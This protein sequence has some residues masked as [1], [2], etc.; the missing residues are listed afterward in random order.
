MNTITK[1]TKQA[2]QHKAQ[3]RK[4]KQLRAGIIYQGPSMIDG[5]P[6]VAIATWTK[7][8]PKT[9]AVLQTY[10]LR[11]DMLPMQAIKAGADKAI[12]GT[13]P[14]R[15]PVDAALASGLP[16]PYGSRSC[17]VNVSRGV[18]V[19]Y[20]A[21]QRG[22]Y[23]LAIRENEMRE[24]GAGRIIRLGTYGDPAAVPARVWMH[25][26]SQSEAHTGYTHAWREERFSTLKAW[27][28]A[29][30]DTAQDH[31]E[32]RAAGWRTFRVR[33]RA[34]AVL[35]AEFICPASEEAGKKVTCSQCKACGGADGRKGSPV[36]IA[37]GALAKRFVI[38]IARSA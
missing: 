35:P 11:A 26:L 25:L 2:G 9:G 30:A 5:S 23:P 31:A 7:S 16:V 24:L 4:P 1:D 13:C 33:D 32:A 14:H 10:I 18:T 15:G 29:S 20:K 36:I 8:N 12:C 37:H 27:T 19:V 22:S 6:I 17:Y 3:T 34:E 28:M 38:N 21:F